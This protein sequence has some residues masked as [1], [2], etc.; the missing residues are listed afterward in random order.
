MQKKVF[1]WLFIC[2][3]VAGLAALFISREMGTDP[4]GPEPPGGIVRLLWWVGGIAWWW[5]ETVVRWFIWPGEAVMGVPLEKASGDQTALSLLVSYVAWAAVIPA[6]LNAL[7]LWDWFGSKRRTRGIE[8]TLWSWWVRVRDWFEE[9]KAFGRGPAS[10]WAGMADMKCRRWHRGDVFLGRPWTIFG[11]RNWPV[12]ISTEKHMVTIAGTGSGK[13][14]AALIPNLCLHEGS[15]LCIDPKGE[16]ARI[17]ARQRENRRGRQLRRVFVLDP[18]GIGG[19]RT[20]SSY[21][22]FNEMTWAAAKNPDRAVSYASRIAE[23]LV[24][25]LSTTDSYWDKAAKTLLTGLVLYIFVHEPEERKNLM[26]LRGLLTEGD[27]EGYEAAIAAGVIARD[28]MSPFDFLIEKMKSVRKGLHGEVIARAACTIDMMGSGQ[29]G[30]VLT[31][32]QEH[33]A[34]IDNPLMAKVLAGN[35]PV[36]RLNDLKEGDVSVYVCLPVTAVNG[37]EGRWLRMFVLMFIEVMMSDPEDAPNPPVLLAIDEFPSL[38]RLDGIEVIA[39][40]MRSYGVRFWAVGQDVS[41]FKEVYPDTWTGFIGGAEAVQFMGI[42]HPPTVD[43]LVDMLGQH[44]VREG[45]GE[46]RFRATHSLMDR[47][48][49]M[50]FLAKDRGNQI[51]WFGSRRPMK[52]KICPYFEY[53][54]PWYYDPD[55]RYRESLWKR[56]VR[57]NGKRSWS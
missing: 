22:P 17:T 32:A 2:P 11:G 1:L 57:R 10:K 40:M 14:T 31:T 8:Q 30:S 7:G 36:L 50:R 56:W 9:V 18:F 51:I 25:P 44:Q 4:L 34:F 6:G 43:L 45:M 54:M 38:G 53:L 20:S 5:G 42:T 12:G 28:D 35:G 46:N 27:V 24:M 41:Q 16:L 23:A 52:L 26:R 15:V 48:Q 21:N 33:T 3:F 13:S 19:T 37:P 47:D 49:V 55:P 39:P 29:R